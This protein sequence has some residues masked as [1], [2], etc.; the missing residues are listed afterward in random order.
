MANINY[1][2]NI[3]KALILRSYFDIIQKGLLLGNNHHGHPDFSIDI[4]RSFGKSMINV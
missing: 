1:H 2:K 3:N 4:L